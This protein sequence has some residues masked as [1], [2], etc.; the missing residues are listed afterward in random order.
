MRQSPLAIWGHALPPDTLA[1]IAR[2]DAALTHPHPVCQDA[3]EAHVVALAAIIGGGLSASEAHAMAMRR[4]E[5]RSLSPEVIGALR[6]AESAPPPCDGDNMGWVLIALQNAWY[7]ALHAPSLEEGL[8]ATVGRGGDTDTNGAIAGA[9]LGALHGAS[10]IPSQ[11][12]GAILT[13]RPEKGRPNVRQPR[14]QALW[15]IDAEALAER[16]ALAGQKAAQEL[17]L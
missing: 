4:A 6:R 2:R 5:V 13:C 11:W 16:L 1:S 12:R 10:A 7:E 17:G 14:P 8:V 3:S 9:L 15:P